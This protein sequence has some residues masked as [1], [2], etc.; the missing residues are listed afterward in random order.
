MINLHEWLWL[1]A[2]MHDSAFDFGSGSWRIREHFS[3]GMMPGASGVWAY[4]WGP[5]SWRQMTKK[6]FSTGCLGYLLGMTSYPIVRRVRVAITRIPKWSNQDDSWWQC[7]P[8]KGLKSMLN[9][10]RNILT[11]RAFNISIPSNKNRPEAKGP[12][13]MGS[14]FG[15]ILQGSWNYPFGRD[16]HW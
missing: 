5:F 12:F 10:K 13:F 2:L 16:Q 8:R 6:G 3:H 4:A 1:S 9:L 11:E 7:Q 15:G 14:G